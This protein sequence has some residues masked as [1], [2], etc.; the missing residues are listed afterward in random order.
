MKEIGSEF[1]EGSTPLDGNGIESIIPNGFDCRYVLSGRTALDII[2]R[3]A[4]RE[5]DIQKVYLPSFCCHSMIE[6]FVNNRIAIEFYSVTFSQDGLKIDFDPNHDCDIVYLLDFFGFVDERVSEMARKE[7]A[8]GT[9]VL[10]DATH[11]LLCAEV[12]YSEYDY[13]FAS[14]RKWFNVNAAIC[15]KKN[16]WDW[17]PTLKTETEFSLARNKAFSEKGLY[18]SDKSDDKETY[19]ERFSAA[20]EW[21]DQH[22][23]DYKPDCDSLKMLESVNIQ[24][25]RMKRRMNAETLVR[26]LTE[27]D[28]AFVYSPYR[29][30][31]EKD[32][33]LMVPIFLHTEH[34]FMLRKHFIE[35]KCYLPIHWPISPCHKI[36]SNMLQPYEEE[37]SLV[38]DQRYSLED[39]DLILAYIDAFL[40]RG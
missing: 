23:R 1:W 25:V 26:G 16:E 28:Q 5:K 36:C 30:L 17:F 31:N 27:F 10:Y 13:V 19:L 4:I 37:L 20:E 12:D 22:Y 14:L 24:Y 2:I 38:C 29:K 9:V 39:M 6:P 35:H 34:R 7:K 15:A 21:L 3:D 18:M 11:S 32:C 33:P 8:R 40:Q